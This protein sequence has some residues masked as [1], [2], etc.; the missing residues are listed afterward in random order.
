[1]RTRCKYCGKELPSRPDPVSSNWGDWE[2]SCGQTYCQDCGESLDYNDEGTCGTCVK[3]RLDK[4][5]SG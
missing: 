1:M 2:C 4:E 3:T 5:S